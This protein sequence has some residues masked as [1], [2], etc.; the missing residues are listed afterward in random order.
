[1]RILCICRSGSVRSVGTKRV[2][3]KRGYYDVLSVGGLIVSRKTLNMLC[4]WA[5]IILLA[6]R[7][8]GKRILSKYRE[9]ID[10]RFHIGEDLEPIVKKQLD[11]IGL[12]V[13]L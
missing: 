12:G 3:N 9:K 1:M 13:I 4:D 11:L 7:K 2:L 8:H 10:Q 5:D 6:K